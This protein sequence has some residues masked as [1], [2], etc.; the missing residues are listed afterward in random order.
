MSWQRFDPVRTGAFSHG[1]TFNN[2][3]IS[4]AAG[5]TGLTEVLTNE[6]SAR[7]NALGD[8]L[9][10]AMQ[11]CIDAHRIAACTT[12]YGSL[13]NLHFLPKG[14]VT[15]ATVESGDGRTLTTVAHGNDAGRAICDPAGHDRHVA[16]A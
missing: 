9:R 14:S 6:A 3:V 4:M 8:R 13:F 15:P 7:F 5:L 16:A 10:M 12:G 11:D 1:G 2:N